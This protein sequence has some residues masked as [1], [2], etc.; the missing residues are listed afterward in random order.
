MSNYFRACNDGLSR[1]AKSIVVGA[2]Y[3]QLSSGTNYR[4]MGVGKAI[5]FTNNEK[6][7]DI[8]QLPEAVTY[9][10]EETGLVW[11]RPVESFCA[12]NKFRFIKKS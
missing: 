2:I 11:V 7:R 10:C 4:I 6:K 5:H 12:Q 1:T 3:K 8:A 9:R